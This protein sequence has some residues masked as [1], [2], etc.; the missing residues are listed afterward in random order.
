ML[1]VR[2]FPIDYHQFLGF[3]NTQVSRCQGFDPHNGRQLCHSAF[4]KGFEN[5]NLAVVG[6]SWKFSVIFGQT[7][8]VNRQLVIYKY[9]FGL[10]ELNS[11]LHSRVI[12]EAFIQMVRFAYVS[13]IL[14]RRVSAYSRYHS[15]LWVPELAGNLKEGRA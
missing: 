13:Y 6:A 5:A 12:E 8:L 10:Q 15:K 11:P 2:V 7:W 9:T 14:L 3:L 1:G 4:G